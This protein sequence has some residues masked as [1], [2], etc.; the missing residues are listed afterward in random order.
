MHGRDNYSSAMTAPIKQPTRATETVPID[1]HAHATLRYIRRSMDG[2]SLL[3]VPGSA[4]IAMG[5]VGVA[6]AAATSMPRWH[7]KWLVIWLVAAVIAGALGGTLMVRQSRIQGHTLFGAPVRKFLLCLLPSI[8]AGALLTAV[9]WGDGN[10]VSVPGVWLLL[11]GC[12][13]VSAT[14]T[15]TRY[16][17]AL[18]VSFAALACCAFVL[19]QSTHNF[20]LGV[21]FG[22][23]HLLFGVLIGRVEHGS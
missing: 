13:L 1:A 15:T 10:P 9:F 18:G 3:T 14:A 16:V 6:A 20:L 4:G 21:G 7:A 12:A 23:L 5:I 22:G 2:A 11:Y 8:F 17:G 19:P